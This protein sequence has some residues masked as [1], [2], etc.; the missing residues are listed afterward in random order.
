[1]SG[2]ECAGIK[3]TQIGERW[4]GKIA[5][6]IVRDPGHVGEVGTL[7]V[8]FRQSCKD[9]EDFRISLGAERGILQPKIIA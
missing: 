2:R 6:Q 8:T 4:M 3:I 1:M 9:A 7:S 5:L